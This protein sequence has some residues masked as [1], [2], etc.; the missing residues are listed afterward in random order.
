MWTRVFITVL[1]IYGYGACGDPKRDN[2]FDPVIGGEQEAGIELIA[3]LPLEAGG[4]AGDPQRLGEIRYQVNWAENAEPL[5]GDMN[6]VGRQARAIVRGV[7]AGEERVFRADIFDLNKIRIFSV[8]DTLSVI[9]G[10]PQT[11][12][13]D[14]QRLNSSL[15]ITSRL[16]PEC[17][18]C[19]KCGSTLTAIL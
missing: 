7:L 3:T 8:S 18:V 17:C 15:E 10:R 9:T 5:T 1:T 14:F 2:P 19:W 6:L 12:R 13:L 16:P 11:V 4:I